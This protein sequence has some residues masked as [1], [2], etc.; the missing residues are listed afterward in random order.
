GGLSAQDVAARFGGPSLSEE[1][2]HRVS[3]L[4]AAD[5]TLACLDDRVTEPALTTPGGE[6]GEFTTALAA[7]LQEKDGSSRSPPNQEVVDSLLGRYVE[8][9]PAS[10]PVVFCTDER[11]LKRIASELPTTNLDLNA[12]S[13][14]LQAAGLLDKLTEP[15]SQGDSHFRLLLEDPG[16]YEVHP[17]LA[18]MVLRAFYRLMWNQNQ[19]PDQ[20]ASPKLR[21]RVF[22]GEPDPQAFLEVSCQ[23]A[24][25]DA[26]AAVAP[27]AGP[28]LT[29]QLDAPTPR[30]KELA[31]FF[32]RTSR[33][34]PRKVSEQSLAERIDQLA[35][36][37][38]EST[39]SRVAALF[40]EFLAKNTDLNN[41]GASLRASA[42]L[43][44][45]AEMELD[46]AVIGSM[47]C[48]HMLEAEYWRF[49]HRRNA[50]RMLLLETQR[51]SLAAEKLAGRALD[52]AHS[53]ESVFESFFKQLE[54]AR[55]PQPSEPLH[56]QKVDLRPLA[57]GI[58]R[59]CLNPTVRASC[60][61]VVTS[62]LQLSEIRCSCQLQRGDLD[63]KLQLAQAA[64]VDALRYPEGDGR[65]ASLLRPLQR[66]ALRHAVIG[67]SL[68]GG[69]W[70]SMSPSTVTLSP[71]SWMDL[72]GYSLEEHLKSPAASQEARSLLRKA[73]AEV[74]A[75]ERVPRWLVAEYY[76]AYAH[77][78][79][80]TFVNGTVEAMVPDGEA[81]WKLQ[82][83]AS[84][85][86][87][88]SCGKAIEVKAKAVVLAMGT[89]D[90]PVR[91][92]IPG[93]DLSWVTHRPPIHTPALMEKIGHLLVV[94]AGLSA[95]D[96]ILHAL[97]GQARVTHVFRGKAK[98]TKIGKMFGTYTG[99]PMYDEEERLAQL[100][101]G[102]VQE[103]RYTPLAESELLAIDENGTCRI[104]GPAQEVQLT[105]VNVVSLLLGS[106][107][108]VSWLPAS[109][110]PAVLAAPRAPRH[111]TDGQLSS[112]PQ[113]LS[114]D[115][116]SFQ[117]ADAETGQVLHPG[118]FDAWG[119][120]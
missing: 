34:T 35:L 7:Y 89:A 41:M 44:A 82:I 32:A 71:G 39:G 70:H 43:V 101:V 13:P 42:A 14:H 48:A 87:V 33:S 20:R 12:P 4:R 105:N 118:V 19:D 11:A 9:V 26:L 8:S 53:Y 108:S 23:G 54:A 47:S 55:F 109:L 67:T 64:L 5:A 50:F 62:W 69:S 68:P 18:P 85:N 119:E 115:E 98:H 114:I 57:A 75:G 112:H 46:V 58:Q 104:R 1:Q 120:A 56:R 28:A 29:S 111:R 81:S 83:A 94:G 88:D 10:R 110:R 92:G 117:L 17:Q 113:F 24:C 30:R 27:G 63:L 96:A 38:L 99:N 74:V 73:P 25:H 61:W 102:A 100:M 66:P 78:L 107:P 80:S 84:S 59:R 40:L 65:G 116:A 106:A 15:N 45:S 52:E 77:R 95:A 22:S 21:L 90:L 103:D 37:A 2:R 36:L 97:R 79:P 51:V 49:Q 93:E 86:E 76:V 16:R 31:A 91:L 6:L 60:Q 72:P 3:L